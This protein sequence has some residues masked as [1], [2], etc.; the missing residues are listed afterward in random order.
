MGI[1][2]LLHSLAGALLAIH[3]ILLRLLVLRIYTLGDTKIRDLH[4]NKP[5]N[6]IKLNQLSPISLNLGRKLNSI[7]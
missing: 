3:F 7:G 2:L 5:N 4:L 1:L 6:Q